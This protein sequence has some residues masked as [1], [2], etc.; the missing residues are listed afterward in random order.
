[1]AEPETKGSA[2]ISAVNAL[3]KMAPPEAFDRMVQALSP[4]AAHL[5]RKLPL[6]IEWLPAKVWFELL[7]GAHEHVFHGNDEKLAEMARVALMSD[8]TTVYKVFIRLLSPQYV[9]ER[10]TRIWETYARNSGH[11]RAESVGDKAADVFYQDLPKQYM[12][13]AYWAY[14]CGAVKGA[15][16]ATGVKGVEVVV[17]AGGGKENKAILRCSWR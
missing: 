10:G 7:Y 5:V 8:L 11:L 3:K 12:R 1:M 9:V 15:I 17:L 6:P 16:E 13:P 14:Q 2:F 4:E